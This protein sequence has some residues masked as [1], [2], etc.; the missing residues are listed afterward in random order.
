M[1]AGEKQSVEN[2]NVSKG[3]D[4][5]VVLSWAFLLFKPGASSNPMLYLLL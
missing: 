2:Y 1:L 5:I 3:Q 4:E